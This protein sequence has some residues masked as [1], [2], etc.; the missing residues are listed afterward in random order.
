MLSAVKLF[1]WLYPWVPSV[2]AEHL[3]NRRCSSHAPPS[4]MHCTLLLKSCQHT[5]WKLGMGFVLRGREK[6]YRPLQWRKEKVIDVG[7]SLQGN[8]SAALKRGQNNKATAAIWAFL[9][10]HFNMI[11]VRIKLN[12]HTNHIWVNNL[13]LR[14]IIFHQF[15]CF[16]CLQPGSSNPLK[17][18]CR[19]TSDRREWRWFWPVLASPVSNSSRQTTAWLYNIT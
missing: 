9:P 11:L 3:S 8:Q 4:Q 12:I 18:Q 10:E 15:R 7:W 1:Q 17:F 6:R 13:Y 2:G 16:K 5:V 19:N 14:L